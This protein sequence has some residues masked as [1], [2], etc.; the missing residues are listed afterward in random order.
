LDM[1][2]QSGLE[3]SYFKVWPE[4]AISALTEYGKKIIVC[5]Y[6]TLH[7]NY[8]KNSHGINMKDVVMGLIVQRYLDSGAPGMTGTMRNNR[9]MND[10]TYRF[11]A[12]PLLK[13]LIHHGVAVDLVGFFRN[14]VHECEDSQVNGV[15]L[16]LWTNRIVYNQDRKLKIAA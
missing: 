11:G 16:Q 14:G 2:Q 12:K 7:K 6:F 1:S 13:D 4:T 3:D 15:V 9:G 5:S 10:C 8:R